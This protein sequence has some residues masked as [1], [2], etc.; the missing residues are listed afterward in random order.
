[1]GR[2]VNESNKLTSNEQ[3]NSFADILIIAEVNKTQ[4]KSLSRRH[5]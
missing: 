1:M 5:L 2:W 3:I 4:G